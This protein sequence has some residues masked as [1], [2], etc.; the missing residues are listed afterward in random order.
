MRKLAAWVVVALASGLPVRAHIGDDIT[1]LRQ[2]YGATGKRAGNAIIFQKNGYSICV[3]FDQDRS[4]MEMFTRD[5]SMKDKTDI[6]PH[7]IDAILALEGDGEQWNQVTSQSGKLT[8]LRA[9]QHLIARLST[10]DQPEDKV[11]MVM[12]NEK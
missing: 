6:T 12:V 7:D 9:D 1:Q 8:W 2:A 4:A 10:G 3:Y 5:G 11:F